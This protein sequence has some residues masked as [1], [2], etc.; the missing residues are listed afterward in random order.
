GELETEWKKTDNKKYKDARNWVRKRGEWFADTWK[1]YGFGMQF[2]ADTAGQFMN[3]SATGE[4]L[5]AR[6]AEASQV[7]SETTK[8]FVSGALLDG[9]N[10]AVRKGRGGW[11]DL[12]EGVSEVY[13]QAKG[14]DG[15]IAKKLVRDLTNWQIL[16]LR[17]DSRAKGLLGKLGFQTADKNSSLAAKK[18][19]EG[20][21]Y[22]WRPNDIY[23]YLLMYTEKNILPTYTSVDNVKYKHLAPTIVDQAI[24]ML[25][26]KE[27][28]GKKVRDYTSEV[29][30][31]AVRKLHKS[32]KDEVF[33]ENMPPIMGL[34]LI[35]I[36]GALLKQA[37]ETENEQ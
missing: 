23:E 4:E 19:G 7:V 11:E 3:R 15:D 22:D 2:T 30:G 6:T 24:A 1:E 34:V 26:G 32:G 14:E 36:I 27:A 20:T 21:A 17:R 10:S 35:A 5:I 18:V 33:F 25:T 37:F 28:Q 8:N 13:S 29:S 12:Y 9:I 31:E 16:A